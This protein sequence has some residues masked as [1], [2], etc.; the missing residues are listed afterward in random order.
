MGIDYGNYTTT[1]L[2]V[3]DAIPSMCRI[4]AI[5]DDPEAT[6]TLKRLLEKHGYMV[7]EENDSRDALAAAME[8]QPDV[9]ILDY[10]MPTVHGGDVAWQIASDRSL[11]E[12][13]LIMCS[14]INAEDLKRRLPPIPIPILEKPVDADALLELIQSP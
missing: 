3:R 12:K 6:G 14:G 7:R 1:P 2:P 9:I 11:R 5:D 4:L 13:K 8:F 10:A